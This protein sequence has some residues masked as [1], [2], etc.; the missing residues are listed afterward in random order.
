MS[1]DITDRDYIGDGVYVGFDGYNIVMTTGSHRPEEADNMIV[2]EPKV[3]AAF[4]RY[5]ASL[6]LARKRREEMTG[7]E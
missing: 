1:N 7:G 4:T 2:L 3:L 6:A 5:Q